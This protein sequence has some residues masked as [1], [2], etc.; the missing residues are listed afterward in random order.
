MGKNVRLTRKGYKIR[1]TR[2]VNQVKNFL[3]TLN[4]GAKDF[5]NLERLLTENVRTKRGL[6]RSKRLEKLIFEEKDYSKISRFKT[7]KDV[8]K[9]EDPSLK[10]IARLLQDDSDFYILENNLIKKFNKLSKKDKQNK[11]NSLRL[12]L[13]REYSNYKQQKRKE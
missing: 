2:R 3:S 6:E 8:K 5:K 4:I 10:S 9:I 11:R 7:F 1:E 13:E 12:Q